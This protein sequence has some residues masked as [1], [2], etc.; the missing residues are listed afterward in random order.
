MQMETITVENIESGRSVEVVMPKK[1]PGLIS[2]VIGKG[3]H[4]VQCDL[5]PDKNGQA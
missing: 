4:S 3:V 5:A 1:R 2:V